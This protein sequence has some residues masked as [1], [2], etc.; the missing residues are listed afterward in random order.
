MFPL[1]PRPRRRSPAR[2]AGTPSIPRLLA[3]G[4]LFLALALT[5]CAPHVTK[6]ADV[7]DLLVAGRVDS[8]LAAFDKAGGKKSDLLYLLE[9]G[10]MLHAA[11]R[12]KESNAFFDA[13]ELRAEDLV[14]KSVSREAAA[15]L[16][17]DLARPYSGLPFELR[18]VPYYRA[19]NYLELGQV[20]EA[21][22]EAR[23]S[24]NAIQRNIYAD[25]T[26]LRTH[27]E[28]F[29]HYVNG[30]VYAAGG[31]RD[32]A[33][34]SLR[35][36]TQLYGGSD[37]AGLPAPE[38]VPEDL[39]R[40]AQRFDSADDQAGL[41]RQD[42]TL[43]DR[44]RQAGPENLVV[45]LESGFVPHREPVDITLP[46]FKK[47]D[48]G[49]APWY[50]DRYRSNIYDYRPGHYRSDFD[51]DHVLRFAF[52]RLEQKPSAITHCEVVLPDG[53][54]IPAE[55]ALDLAAVCRE[56]FDHRL[57]KILLKSVARAIAKE[58]AR[59]AADKKGDGWGLLV[60]IFGAVTEQADT[61]SWL[62]L[63]ARIDVAR[64]SIP[65]GPTRVVVRYLDDAGRVVDEQSLQLTCRDGRTEF[66]QFRSFR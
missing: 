54:R 32:D 65:P 53:R 35:L 23:K 8:A 1:W 34:V 42:K 47:D 48:Y 21:L 43:P 33:L 56:D 14:T 24:T 30:L 25:S 59:K 57:P 17:S 4:L 6:L 10:T 52:P 61:R 63:P 60:N 2:A 46:I 58:S 38:T 44:V 7:R 26:S 36:A 9:R 55:P 15:F 5:G 37:A 18:M 39:Y 12:W 11:G 29:L 20:D 66:A 31:E 50:V 19:L 16:T 41:V 49:S 40:M 27:Q 28:A 62:L 64:V 51:L 13:A 3:G 45:F 22:V